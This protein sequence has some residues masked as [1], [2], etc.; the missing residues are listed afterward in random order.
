VTTITTTENT[1]IG[2]DTAPVAHYFN[3]LTDEVRIWDKALQPEDILN[4]DIS[5]VKSADTEVVAP[6]DT[7][8]YSYTVTN[9]GNVPLLDVTV[10]D[11]LAGDAVYV[12]GDD[13]NVFLEVGEIWIFTAN[14]VVIFNDLEW[15]INIATA[16]GTDEL[17]VTVGDEDSWTI[18]NM[19]ARTIGY[20]KTHPDTWCDFPNG[21]MFANK[22]QEPVLLE[23]VN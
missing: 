9:V 2:F 1:K 18:Y 14:Y 8:T 22:E 23:M 12:S 15:L 17:D 19:G 16:I 20:W 21:S 5:V 10:N 11:D 3:G 13:C 7:V 4:P 6:G